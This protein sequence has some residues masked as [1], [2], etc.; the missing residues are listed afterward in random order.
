MKNLLGDLM[1]QAEDIKAKAEKIQNELKESCVTGEA[2]G[3]MVKITVNGKFEVEKVFMEDSVFDGKKTMLED[4]V[5][6]AFND[7]SRKVAEMNKEKMASI[8]GGLEI[9]FGFNSSSS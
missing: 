6:A 7:A 1:R 3:G 4:L 8:T 9:P 2:G 5:A